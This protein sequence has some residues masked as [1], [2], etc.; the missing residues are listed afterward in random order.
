MSE[1]RNA[2]RAGLVKAD[3]AGFV[4]WVERTRETHR[5]PRQGPVGLTSTFDPPYALCG[6]SVLSRDKPRSNNADNP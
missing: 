5:M 2:A 1:R 4:G 3:A 6:E